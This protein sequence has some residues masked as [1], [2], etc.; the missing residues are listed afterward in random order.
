MIEIVAVM[1]SVVVVAAFQWFLRFCA[2]SCLVVVVV[3]VGGRSY[4]I[5]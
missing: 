1:N 2:P 5:C 3:V 4:Y